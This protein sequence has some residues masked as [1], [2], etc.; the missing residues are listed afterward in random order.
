MT[1]KKKNKQK[2]KGKRIAGPKVSYTKGYY[3]FSKEF[4]SVTDS[5]GF[6]DNNTFVNSNVKK[7]AVRRG[8]VLLFGCVFVIAFCITALCFAISDIPVEKTE[9]EPQT[10]V[11]TPQSQPVKKMLSYSGDTLAT[12]GTERI[13]SECKT[14]GA[15]T[16][17][18]ELKD[19]Q[20]HFY[21]KPSISV[22]AEAQ[23]TIIVNIQEIIKELK[24]QGLIVFASVS[25]FADDIYARNNQSV[26]TYV[27]TA[28]DS[29]ESIW[30]GGEDGANA[31]LSPFSNEVCYYLT[32]IISDVADLGV[33]GIVFENATLPVAAVTE[34]VRFS[35]SEGFEVSPQKKIA[36][37]IEYTVSIINCKTA[38]TLSS[39][40]LIADVRSESMADNYPDGCD[41]VILDARPSDADKGVSI[42]GLQ[43]LE[44][45]RTPKEYVSALLS[46]CSE[47]FTSTNIDMQIIAVV[48]NSSLVEL[49][50]SA[51]EEQNIN[52]VV[53]K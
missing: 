8:L 32:T 13:V 19:A 26:A 20:G 17:I 38:I 7:A 25:C 36:D 29:P 33:D 41:Y 16:V 46:L 49:Q 1:D 22:S 15:D 12:V 35:L 40:Q 53:L 44:P 21:F 34:D 30:Y 39:Q 51:A 10:S 9:K 52:T 47:K 5:N 2:I 3:R 43:Y 31:W 11:N 23:A 6:R 24:Q 14:A 27:Q 4:P 28:Q 50:L 48:D 37:W 18:I 45:E 42:S